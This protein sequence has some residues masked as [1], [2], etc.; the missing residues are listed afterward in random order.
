MNAQIISFFS[1]K[2][3]TS[4]TTNV[5]LVAHKLAKSGKRVLLV[6]SDPQG[7]LST[8]CS[9]DIER[10]S[11]GL[12]EVLIGT[13]PI[14]SAVLR[15]PTENID[16]LAVK[17]DDE[18]LEKILLEHNPKGNRL[19]GS[20]LKTRFKDLDSK[21][22][23]IKDKYDFILVDTNPAFGCLNFNAIYASDYVVSCILPDDLSFLS[24][25]KIEETIEIVSSQKQKPVKHIGCIISLFEARSK[26]DILILQSIRER[27]LNI[28]GVIPKATD[29][30]N[31]VGEGKMPTNKKVL[32][33]LHE[34]TTQILNE[35]NKLF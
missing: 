1:R 35:K 34:I 28:L 4:K 13:T 26:L 7:N 33:A 12:T 29:V 30:K 16:I 27:G 6:D 10:E 14:D 3:G 20:H 18:L 8:L 19:D 23:Q 11:S 15:T 22:Q 21:L 31:S 25:E 32:G 24:I 2:G 17:N 9:V 5:F